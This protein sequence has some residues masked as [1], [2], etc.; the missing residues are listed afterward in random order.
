MTRTSSGAIG[1]WASDRPDRTSPSRRG[2]GSASSG[3]HRI[4]AASCAT[5]GVVGSVAMTVRTSPARMTR[6][7]GFHALGRRLPLA[8]GGYRRAGVEGQR[9]RGH[10]RHHPRAWC[11]VGHATSFPTPEDAAR[12][13][14]PCTP[15][16]RDRL[17]IPH[18]PAQIEVPSSR[19]ANR[20]TGRVRG[21]RP[22]D[23]RR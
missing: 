16:A 6:G 22:T 8:I 1:I 20:S 23:P 15:K 9:R 13:Q 12:P 5:V 17:S 21:K 19:G 2:S 4:A 10:G 3:C 7:D 18:D 14:T 11:E